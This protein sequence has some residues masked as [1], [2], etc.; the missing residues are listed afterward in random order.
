MLPGS[1]PKSETLFRAG[2]VRA[3]MPELAPSADVSPR[4]LA[5][6]KARVAN[7]TA[8]SRELS[9]LLEDRYGIG[10]SHNRINEILRG[11]A[12]DGLFRETMI[13]DESLFQ[14]YLF[15]IAFFYPNFEEHWEDCYYDL[16]EDPHVLMFFNAD[17]HYHWQFIAQFR[18]NDQMERWVHDFFKRNGEL[19]AQFHNTMLHN[20][21]KFRTDAEIFDDIL[22][23]SPEGR[24]YLAEADD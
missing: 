8:S 16:V 9:E 7:P 11:L 10:L 24:E 5:I 6:L 12:E 17:S 15:R 23:E 21:H 2:W 13:P 19:I 3:R 20:V 4:D 14:H 22:E 1:G 18:S